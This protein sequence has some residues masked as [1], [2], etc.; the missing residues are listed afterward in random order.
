MLGGNIPYSEWLQVKP[1][2]G[3]SRLKWVTEFEARGFMK[4]LTPI[5][6]RTI[7]QGQLQDLMKLKQILDK[8]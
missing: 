4:L 3:G 5:L 6:R 1:N 8:H 7:R 2:N